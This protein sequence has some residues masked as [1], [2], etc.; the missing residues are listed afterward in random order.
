MIPTHCSFADCGA[1]LDFTPTTPHTRRQYITRCP[2][3]RRDAWV[4]ARLP[5]TT[6]TTPLPPVGSVS[7]YRWCVVA[8]SDHSHSHLTV[9]YGHRTIATLPRRLADHM[10]A[11]HCLH[12]LGTFPHWSTAT[13]SDGQPLAPPGLPWVH[14]E[15]D[16]AVAIACTLLATDFDH[17]LHDVHIAPSPP[18]AVRPVPTI[19]VNSNHPPPPSATAAWPCGMYLAEP[20]RFRPLYLSNTAASTA[21]ERRT[22]DRILFSDHAAFTPT[23]GRLHADGLLALPGLGPRY[24]DMCVLVGCALY[25]LPIFATVPHSTMSHNDYNG[26]RSVPWSDPRLQLQLRTELAC[27]DL[28]DVTSQVRVGAIHRVHPTSTRLKPGADS[29]GQPLPDDA[30]KL[31][32][33]DDY[34]FQWSTLAPFTSVNHACHPGHLPTIRLCSVNDVIQHCLLLQHQRSD[35]TGPI[36]LWKVDAA[37]AF[38]HVTT[39]AAHVWMTCTPIELDGQ[40]IIVAD[41]VTP[42]GRRDSAAAFCQ[43]S[44][45][46]NASAQ[47]Q[48]ART[49]CYSDDINGISFAATALRDRDI[50]TSNNTLCGLATNMSKLL[51]AE[52]TPSP[53]QP[54]LGV[55]IN[56]QSM[57][58]SVTT[59]RL[60]KL[61]AAITDALA[62]PWTSAK[63]LCTLTHKLRFVSECM[64]AT[65][66]MLQ[67]LFHLVAAAQRAKPAPRPVALP[68]DAGNNPSL[69]DTAPAPPVH[70]PHLPDVHGRVYLN[71]DVFFALHF[72]R[73]ELT[74]FHLEPASFDPRFQPTLPTA[75]T[76]SD[77]AG[78]GYACIELRSASIVAGIWS[79][80]ELDV[81]ITQR[82]MLAVV[83]GIVRF[84]SVACTPD[85]QSSSAAAAEPPLTPYPLMCCLCDNMST[86]EVMRRGYSSDPV[87]AFLLCVA[88]RAQVQARFH[89]DVYHISGACNIAADRASR[90]L[91]PAPNC[92][93]LRRC[94]LPLRLRSMLDARLSRSSSTASTANGRSTATRR[95]ADLVTSVTSLAPTATQRPPYRVSTPSCS[96]SSCG[97]TTLPSPTGA[98]SPPPHSAPTCLASAPSWL[99]GL[100]RLCTVTPLG[101]LSCADSR[102]S[103]TL[104]IIESLFQPRSSPTPSSDQ[105]LPPVETPHCEQP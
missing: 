7:W 90:Q 33:I 97:Y 73:R 37:N 48:G 69:V 18:R 24:P 41:T 83:F 66:P 79:S 50:V 23:P 100:T 58:T 93:P 95:G 5:C 27:G 45:A 71:T 59:G 12:L 35:A 22:P 52:G 55:D 9:R 40:R 25:G 80:I 104:D 105:T 82:E 14:H 28:V 63:A 98:H 61:T 43:Y 42:F 21:T 60:A 68:D 84:A 49:F 46:V 38:R 92:L 19:L 51:S 54:V 34:S 62:W 96:T 77:A 3:C 70:A 65:R 103:P 86:V 64:P 29:H 85:G 4:L 17:R 36:E 32:F 75:L 56:V 88:A 20:P 102:R 31:R 13:N 74:S 67:P 99:Y 76:V 1:A 89:V 11:Q 72:W 10:R 44:N 94:T 91:P 101:R 78:T 15:A 81:A 53:S 87:L 30:C 6:A 8:S 39:A 57:T 2:Q 26:P 47:R 16:L